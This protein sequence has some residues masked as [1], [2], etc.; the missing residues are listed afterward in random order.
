[1]HPVVLTCKQSKLAPVVQTLDSTIHRINHYPVDSLIGFPT[2]YAMD[3]D[4]SV[5]QRYPTFET[6][7]MPAAC[8]EREEGRREKNPSEK[9]PEFHRSHTLGASRTVFGNTGNTKSNLEYLFD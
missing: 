7:N 3:S 2:T 6:T 5:G 8:V 1:M 9:G 4:L